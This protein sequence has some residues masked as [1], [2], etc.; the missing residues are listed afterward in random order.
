MRRRAEASG[1]ASGRA[2]ESNHSRLPVP[3]R[4][5]MVRGSGEPQ[6]EGRA[7]LVMHSEQSRAFWET[8]PQADS[9]GPI[10]ASTAAPQSFLRTSLSHLRGTG[11]IEERFPYPQHGR[12]NSHSGVEG[13]RP[14][15]LFSNLKPP[16]LLA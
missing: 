5:S 16:N 3:A 1:S 7:R 9:S 8:L 15:T 4:H 11:F 13:E 2:T 6:F 10:L 12:Q 14:F